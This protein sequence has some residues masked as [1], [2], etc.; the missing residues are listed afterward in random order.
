ME[1]KLVFKNPLWPRDGDRSGTSCWW[2]RYPKV[3]C[4]CRSFSFLKA[5]GRLPWTCFVINQRF[6]PTNW[7]SPFRRRN[8][9]NCRHK[10]PLAGIARIRRIFRSAEFLSLSVAVGVSLAI[11]FFLGVP[12]HCVSAPA[13]SNFRHRK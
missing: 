6:R 13:S 4:V 7:T 5:E 9:H 2:F 11:A 8:Q 12:P 3:D 1:R 10:I